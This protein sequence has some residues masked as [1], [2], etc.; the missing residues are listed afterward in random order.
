MRAWTPDE[1]D[2]GAEVLNDLNEGDAERP[3][4]RPNGRDPELRTPEPLVLVVVRWS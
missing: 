1:I 3:R 2:D 4:Y